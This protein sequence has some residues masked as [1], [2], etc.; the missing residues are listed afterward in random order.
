MGAIRE[1]GISKTAMKRLIKQFR[2]EYP[3]RQTRK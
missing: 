1:L 2:I 3:I